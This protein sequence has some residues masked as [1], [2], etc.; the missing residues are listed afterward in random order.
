MPVGALKAC[1]L[2]HA[3]VSTAPCGEVALFGKRPRRKM[4]ASALL[5][6]HYPF[7][8]PF[9]FA[10]PP[11]PRFL[12][13]PRERAFP[14]GE[15]PRRFQPSCPH[16]PPHPA[17]CGLVGLGSAIPGYRLPCHGLGRN[18][19]SSQAFP[20]QQQIAIIAKENFRCTPNRC[21]ELEFR[22]S[23]NMRPSK[24]A[25]HLL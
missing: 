11:A 7:I 23:A 4:R 3:V 17:H 14:H 16:A 21:R 25:R 2:Q 24:N 19:R 10:P 20:P 18:H 5:E 15:V 12:P 6:I 13:A 9:H 1:R 8:F 22:C